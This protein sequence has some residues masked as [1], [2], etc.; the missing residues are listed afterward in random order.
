MSM[1]MTKKVYPSFISSLHPLKRSISTPEFGGRSKAA[2]AEEESGK[3]EAVALT[4]WKKSLLLNCNGFT[5]FDGKGNLMFR[6]DN[7][8]A[9][10][11]AAEIVLMDAIG[12]SLLT[13]RRK[14]LSWGDKWLVYEGEASSNPKY[15]VQKQTNLLLNSN[16]NKALS[17][18][19]VFKI[20]N[21]EIRSPTNKN[22]FKEK[23]TSPR[24]ASDNA[25]YH[26]EGSYSQRRV[27][28]YNNKRRC[29]AEIKRKEGA[30]GVVLG[31]D[32]FRLLILRPDDI[33]TAMAMALV[34]LL[35][36][37]FGSS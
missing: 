2:E 7:Y 8:V 12:K 31:G 1:K 13:I 20:N 29:V 36:Q 3:V 21:S 15:L 26:M 28:V 23:I 27:M 6:V 25:I 17:L 18:A 10:N 30:G 16:S 4:V 5:V 34:I 37:M 32:V 14:K 9:A 22:S 11:K 35:D 24:K 33:D 19:N